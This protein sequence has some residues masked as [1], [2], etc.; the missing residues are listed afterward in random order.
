MVGFSARFL[1]FC[2]LEHIRADKAFDRISV[3]DTVVVVID[4][5][6]PAAAS[7]KTAPPPP[8]TVL[9]TGQ[10][11]TGFP[12]VVGADGAISLPYLGNTKIAELSIREAEQAIAKAF[13]DKDILRPERARVAL[14]HIAKIEFRE[15]A[16]TGKVL[17][18][19]SVLSAEE[20]GADSLATRVGLAQ[21][22]LSGTPLNE[23]GLPSFQDTYGIL[24]LAKQEVLNIERTEQTMASLRAQDAAVQGTVH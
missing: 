12:F 23:I 24:Q 18:Q 3:G 22:P 19:A 21:L 1:A 8:V 14:T 4:G 2:V 17:R 15:G 10:L 20:V 7:P 6:L 16:A 13:V 5:V 9:P 11:V